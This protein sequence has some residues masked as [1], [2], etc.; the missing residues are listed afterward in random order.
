MT[1]VT[2]RNRARKPIPVRR[3]RLVNQ[4]PVS[5]LRTAL[6]LKSSLFNRLSMVSA[7]TSPAYLVSRKG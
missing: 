6:L 2:L 3:Y 7:G 1:C 5:I 4:T